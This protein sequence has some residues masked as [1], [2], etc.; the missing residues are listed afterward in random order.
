MKANTHSVDE[1][2]LGIMLNELRLPT[3]KTLWPDSPSNPIAKAGL[4]HTSW[5]P[6]PNMSLP[7]G[8]LAEAHLP[9]GGRWHL[10]A[11]ALVILAPLAQ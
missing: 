3:I 6:L 5:R 4:P 9:P 7:S 10:G 1:A 11:T 8:H 2:R